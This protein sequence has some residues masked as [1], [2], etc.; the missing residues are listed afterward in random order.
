MAPTRSQILRALDGLLERSGRT[1]VIEGPP[2]SGKSRILRELRGSVAAQGGRIVDLHGSYRNRS[3]PLA[4]L[5]GLRAA[6]GDPPEEAPPDA[7][8]EDVLIENV[9]DAPMAPVLSDPERMPRARRGRTDRGRS[10]FL[11]QPLRPRSANEGDANA[12]WDELLPEFRGENAHPVLLSVEDAALFDTESR[13]FIITLSRRAQFRPLLIA[14]AL[15]T[16]VPDSTLWQELLLG[17]GDVDWVR[18]F[19]SV[20]DPRETHRLKSLFDYLPAATQ[21]VA[22][23]V[24]LLGG[25]VNEVVLSRVCRLGFGRLG[26]ALLPASEAGLVKVVDGK[27][28]LPH[29]AW[30]PIL[31]ELIP[32]SVR[33]VIH[34][35]IADALGALSPAADASRESQIARHYFAAGPGPM[36]MAHLLEAAELNLRLQSFDSAAELLADATVCLAAI[37]PGERA[38][39][40]PEVRLLYAR[41]LFY[42]GR[43]PEAEAQVREGFYAAIRA[44]TSATDLA[45]WVEPLLLA[46]RVVGP[47]PSLVATLVDLAERCHDARLTEVEVILETLIADFYRDRNLPERARAEALRAAQLAHGLPERHLQA[48]GLLTMSFD[49][50]EGKEREQAQAERYLR[51][52][53]YL[54]GTTRRRELDYMAG[55]FEARLYEARGDVDRARV[56]REQSIAPLQ[57]D[58]LLSLELYHVLGLAEIL[59]DRATPAAY[60][61]HLARART[62]VDTLHLSPPSPGLL[63]FWLLD[64]RRHAGPAITRPPATDGPRSSTFRPPRPFRGSGPKRSAA[65]PSTTSPS[66]ATTKRPS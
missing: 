54:L 48:L 51:S 5:D 25:E 16:S 66:A 2:M 7:T 42:S 35:E 28:T 44:G 6:P 18:L 53:R 32:E 24:A 11:G 21:R 62:I 22:G 15:D 58:R 14:L 39:I 41:A 12:Y 29:R 30:I 52:S 43:S 13:E 26:E 27:V 17:R 33:R 38:P 4:G 23:F 46:M 45:E 59:L 36:A 64:G 31:P 56:L 50:I 8:E 61:A 3:L 20:V 40:E 37:P 19:D 63:K 60:E 9:T 34:L 55:E 1:L 57:R 10:T 47:R 65:L 49:G